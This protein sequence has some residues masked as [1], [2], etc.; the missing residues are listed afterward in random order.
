VTGARPI[1]LDPKRIVNTCDSFR[2]Q[3][4]RQPVW[5]VHATEKLWLGGESHSLSEMF[6]AHKTGS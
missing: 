6:G 4:P 2:L 1:D 5:K 3:Y